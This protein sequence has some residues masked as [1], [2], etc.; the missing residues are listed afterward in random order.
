MMIVKIDVTNVVGRTSDRINGIATR[1][2]MITT[3]KM[4][5]SGPGF[6]GPNKKSFRDSNGESLFKKIRILR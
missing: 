3:T 1:A 6:G 5:A 4:V 2:V